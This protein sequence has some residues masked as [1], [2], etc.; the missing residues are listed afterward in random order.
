MKIVPS[1]VISEKL[2]Q[3][4]VV[5]VE[6]DITVRGLTTKL[7]DGL[8]G[9]GGAHRALMNSRDARTD[10]AEAVRCSALVRCP[11]RD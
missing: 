9:A 3:Y 6:V 4:E 7:S 1:E 2:G 10:G 5:R 11:G 8:G